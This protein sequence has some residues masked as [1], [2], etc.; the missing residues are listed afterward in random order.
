MDAQHES[1][2]RN[3][4]ETSMTVESWMERWFDER[5]KCVNTYTLAWMGQRSGTHCK[6]WKTREESGMWLEAGS[7]PEKCE[8]R[9]FP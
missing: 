4:A 8:R 5:G 2:G 9:I 3:K 7:Q 6:S 1:Q